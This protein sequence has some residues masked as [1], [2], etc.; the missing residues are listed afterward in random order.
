MDINNS[1]AHGS[2]AENCLPRNNVQERKEKKNER[3]AQNKTLAQQLMDN[4]HWTL[5]AAKHLI[6]EAQDNTDFNQIFFA[7]WASELTDV[8]GYPEKAMPLRN[9]SISIECKTEKQSIEYQKI[10]KLAG[11][12]V[13]VKGNL[14]M[15]KSK[16]V[17]R[18]P[19]LR[20]ASEERIIK[21]FS[22]QGVIDAYRFKRKVNGVLQDTLS[23]LLTFRTPKPP[24][25][26]TSYWMKF[27]LEKYNEKPRQCFNCQMYGHGAKNCIRGYVCPNCAEDHQRSEERCNKETKCINC[28]ENHN[29]ND[30]KC[31]ARSFEEELIA[32]R[33]SLGL[34]RHD[35]EDLIIQQGLFQ[36]AHDRLLKERGDNS[37]RTQRKRKNISGSS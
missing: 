34:R 36:K 18:E 22:P 24:E 5:R 37:K 21:E 7:D 29:S 1:I 20:N 8:A 10:K 31:E 23:V 14:F 13:E 2:K 11:V 26:L 25:Y 35:L 16:A 19:I 12:P 28:N 27:H 30:K 32:K 15:N 9:G 4:E 33:S 6:V 3:M 17:I